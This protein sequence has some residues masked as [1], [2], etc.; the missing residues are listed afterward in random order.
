[1]PQ[2]IYEPQRVGRAR[3][4]RDN[5]FGVANRAHGGASLATREQVECGCGE[6]RRR[7]EGIEPILVIGGSHPIADRQD[8]GA[9][10]A[11]A[12]TRNKSRLG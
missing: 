12:E 11:V 4:Q 2:R 1:M 9:D 6:M 10:V 7:I 5:E 3:V 8:D